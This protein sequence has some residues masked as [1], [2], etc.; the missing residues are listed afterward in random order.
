MHEWIICD[1]CAVFQSPFMM[2]TMGKVTT[3]TLC[4]MQPFLA[5]HQL[6]SVSA[7]FNFN[8][9]LNDDFPAFP[10]PLSV[11]LMR[12]E[13]SDLFIDTICVLFLLC[14]LHKS[15]FVSVVFDFNASLNDV[16]PVSPM[17]FPAYFMR[18]EKS[19]L[20]MDDICVVSFVITTQIEF[21]ECCV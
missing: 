9:S 17:S 16:A 18:M 20:L 21:R 6:S 11:D 15:S 19:G 12:V 4:S 7:V 10:M 3:N 1:R 14:S 5:L 2:K 8:A 13:K